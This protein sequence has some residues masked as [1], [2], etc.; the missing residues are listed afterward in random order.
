M[1]ILPSLLRE[2]KMS[3]IFCTLISFCS[4]FGVIILLQCFDEKPQANHRNY[5][6]THDWTS[7]LRLYSIRLCGRVFWTTSVVPMAGHIACTAAQAGPESG[8]SSTKSS[9]LSL[10]VRPPQTFLTVISRNFN[11]LSLCNGV[12]TGS[13]MCVH[14]L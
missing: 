13:V 3:I 4:Y 7:N 5:R 8:S 2:R 1:I 9:N 6:S 11:G 10:A 14:L 12:A